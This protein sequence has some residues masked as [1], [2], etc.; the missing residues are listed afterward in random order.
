MSLKFE[1]SSISSEFREV[2]NEIYVKNKLRFSVIIIKNE[3]IENYELYDQILAQFA[4]ESSF[5][6]KTLVFELTQLKWHYRRFFL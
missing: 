6:F 1:N 4:Q 2:L 3:Y 5:T